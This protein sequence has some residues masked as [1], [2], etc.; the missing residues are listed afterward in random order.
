MKDFIF[1]IHP[2][3]RKKLKEEIK[4]EKPKWV[5]LFTSEEDI[6]TISSYLKPFTDNKL[7]TFNESETEWFFNPGD[8][9]KKCMNMA[10]FYD[11]PMSVRGFNITNKD[12]WLFYTGMTETEA[13]EQIDK[14]R[15]KIRK[16][17]K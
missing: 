15:G 17:I 14:W 5:W 8:D 2:W 10:I 3:N 12:F 7:M 11:C 1:C 9:L 4:K 13:F 16:L 6:K